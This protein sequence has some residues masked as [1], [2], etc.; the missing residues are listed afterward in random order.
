MDLK[1]IWYS[2]LILK[3]KNIL[4]KKKFR[5]TNMQDGGQNRPQDM[6]GLRCG[7]V[8]GF[9][10]MKGVLFMDMQ[11]TITSRGAGPSVPLS[12]EV[13]GYHLELSGLSE[14][15][16]LTI[17]EDGGGL[18]V[19]IAAAEDAPV[20]EQ[21]QR[22]VEQP[23]EQAEPVSEAVEAAAPAVQPAIAEPEQLFQRLVALRRQ[24]AA[25]VKLP[26]YIIFHDA[27]LRTMSQV[28]PADMET[29]K[30]IQ[31]VGQA[32][33]EKYGA[34]FIQAIREYAAGKAA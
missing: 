17:A 3:E 34:C 26:P 32:K 28:L 20:S 12:L 11:L 22:E 19:R 25:E 18:A 7:S 29:L 8:H 24:I 31:G 4:Q 15:M 23:V 33:L 10:S 1:L 14:D 21:T 5:L 2:S 30:A 16:K 9:R 27:T 13:S 6:R